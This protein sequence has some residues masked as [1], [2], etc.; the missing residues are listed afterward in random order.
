MYIY[1]VLSHGNWCKYYVTSSEL[2][3]R[4]KSYQYTENN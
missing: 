2:S 3:Y 4:T 1:Y